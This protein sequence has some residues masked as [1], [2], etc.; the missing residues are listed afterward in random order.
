[1]RAL[2]AQIEGLAART[3]VLMLF[4]D[5]QWSDPTSLELYDLIIDRVSALRTLLIV[6]FRPEFTPPWIGRPH[7]TLR[8]LNR[9]APRLRAEMIAGITGGKTLPEEVAAQIIDRTDG[10]P[11]FVEELTKA[12]VESGM[13]TDMGDHYT[14]VEPV[15]HLAIPASLQASLLA[16]L[17]RLAPVRE[18]AQIGAAVGRQFSHQLI[19]GVAS[20]PLPRLEDALAQL[21]GAGGDLPS[22]H[23]AQCRVHLQAR[24]GPGCRLRHLIARPTPPAPCSDRSNPGRRVPGDCLG[25]ARV[26]SSP[27][28]RGRTN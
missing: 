8:A 14:A 4:E 6:T 12:V 22:R 2:V 10:V 13:L 9:L 26:V 18:V 11:L 16:R 7:V 19:A 17:D 20:M 1:L 27:L 3:P 24:A 5:A 28:H 25:R 23:P 21:V 15:A